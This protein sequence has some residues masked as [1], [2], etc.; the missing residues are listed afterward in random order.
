ML[1]GAQ[2][3]L[4]ETI[5]AVET[6]FQRI[7]PG[8]LGWVAGLVKR[9][10]E[11]MFGPILDHTGRFPWWGLA[12]ALIITAGVYLFDR[13][14][15]NGGF[16]R[17]CFPPEIWRSKSTWVDVKVGFLNHVL[18]GGG[19]I[20]VTWRLSTA[21]FAAWVPRLLAAEFG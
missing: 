16:L 17:Y 1:M 10:L 6:L 19:V 18:F 14:R 12:F 8:Y 13:S 20:N 4:H 2:A 7:L 5:Q 11:Y 9:A 21:F 3:F 15:P